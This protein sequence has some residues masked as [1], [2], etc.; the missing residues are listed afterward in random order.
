ML[1]EAVQFEELSFFNGVLGHLHAQSALRLLDLQHSS[2]EFQIGYTKKK[3]SLLISYFGGH[4]MRG[5]SPFF[6][7]M[8]LM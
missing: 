3:S 5:K 6:H 7:R 2:M 8:S 4:L 1:F